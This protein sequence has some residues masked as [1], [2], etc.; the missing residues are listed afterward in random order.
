MKVIDVKDFEKVSPVFR[1]RLGNRLAQLLMHLVAFDKVNQVYE[2]SGQFRGP[3]FAS[4]LLADLG[5]N[6]RVGYAERLAQIP[7]G[8]FI[9][10]SNHPYGGIDGIILIELLA[11]IRSDYR[12]MV[13]K[14]IALVETMKENFITVYPAGNK[15]GAITA[16]SLA[17]IRDTLDWLR[18]GHPVGFFPSGA[19][20]DLQLPSFRIRD[21]KWQRSI[22]NLI[23]SAQVPVLPLRF[24]DG[25][26]PLFYFLGLVHPRVR[27]MRMPHEV[28][29]KRHQSPRL[30]VGEW[31]PP[32]RLAGFDR[33]EHVEAYLRQA[34][35]EM[36]LP[37]E[38]TPRTLLNLHTL[39]P[40]RRRSG[41][42]T[43]A[44]WGT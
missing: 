28:F 39:S 26:L 10:I 1:G 33:V 22:V 36:P 12:L 41:L 44:H 35:Y 32:E 8:A 29:N 43:P 21:R 14:V 4:H 20:S 9:T 16:A 25:N 7:E 27:L 11:G 5:V 17:G 3:E 6:Y 38:W 31:I 18:K 37:R 40:D 19:V 34:V 15:K 42:E 23:R 13:N 2:N 30:A 24:F